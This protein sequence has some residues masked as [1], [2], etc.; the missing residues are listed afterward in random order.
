MRIKVRG[1]LAASD[2][3]ADIAAKNRSVPI[4]LH[5]ESCRDLSNKPVAVDGV[6]NSGSNGI[7]A[8]VNFLVC[9]ANT[10]GCL[11]PGVTVT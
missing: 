1:G 4:D 3:K 2:P 10:Q 8:S 11:P 6:P 9:A 5:F 7:Q